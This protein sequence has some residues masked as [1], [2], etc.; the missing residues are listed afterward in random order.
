MWFADQYTW[1]PLF[2]AHGKLGP[3]TRSP[4]SL[5]GLPP[6]LTVRFSP[7]ASF[8]F[9]SLMPF[10]LPASAT[11]SFPCGSLVF[12][13]CPLIHL[14]PFRAQRFRTAFAGIALSEQWLPSLTSVCLKKKKKNPHHPGFMTA[15]IPD[16]LRFMCVY[17]GDPR[18]HTLNAHHEWLRRVEASSLFVLSGKHYF[19]NYW[20]R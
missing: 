19:Y 15:W 14:L 7:S 17:N 5:P 2:T 8:H 16:K 4:W 20:R 12:S 9:L 13:V 1:R 10:S 6:L 3:P 18:L 11:S